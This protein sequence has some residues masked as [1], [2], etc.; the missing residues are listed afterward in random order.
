M[1]RTRDL[2]IRLEQPIK[3]SWYRQEDVVLEG[4]SLLLT[5]PM[6]IEI[7]SA[8][9]RVLADAAPLSF[10]AL[11]QLILRIP[12]DKSGWCYPVEGASVLIQDKTH[13]VPG[14][15]VDERIDNERAAR[16]GVYINNRFFNSWYGFGPATAFESGSDNDFG[17]DGWNAERRATFRRRIQSLLALYPPLRKA[18][19][20]P[21]KKRAVNDSGI[22]TGLFSD[23]LKQLLPT[24]KVN[25]RKT[26]LK[27]IV[28]ASGEDREAMPGVE[29]CFS[30][31]GLAWEALLDELE[32]ANVLG[33]FDVQNPSE[34]F[35][36][37]QHLAEAVGIE[38]KY[39]LGD[40]STGE[41]IGIATDFDRWLESQNHCL[42]WPTGA[43]RCDDD[44]KFH[45]IIVSNANI[46]TVLQL[47][48]R[49]GPTRGVATTK[50]AFS[51]DS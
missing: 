31:V 30:P 33:T 46:D 32:A 8:L 18:E 48:E 37:S 17:S 35:A 39:E 19:R 34:A 12:P 4:Q 6:R 9:E 5:A 28:A 1:R 45:A 20:K 23:L 2:D 44:E 49:L 40:E 27:R 29:E 24:A 22:D 42:I 51:L 14:V 43:L 41:S 7:R 36:T 21:R 16:G 25:E 47:I 11:D 13:E 3:Y 26:I 38:A 10:D 15:W 50:Q